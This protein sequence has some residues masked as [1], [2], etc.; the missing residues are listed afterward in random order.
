MGGAMKE[1]KTPSLLPVPPERPAILPAQAAAGEKVAPKKWIKESYALAKQEIG[2]RTT[3]ETQ[4][5][6]DLWGDKKAE[7]EEEGKKVTLEAVGIDITGAQS[8][9]KDAL[10]VMLT[11]RNYK[12]I[13]EVKTVAKYNWTGNLEIEFTIAEYLK[14]YG[15]KKK[16]YLVN[17][18]SGKTI[19][20]HEYARADV[21][22]AITALRELATKDFALYLTQVRYDTEAKALKYE[23]DRYIDKL[24][25]FVEGWKDLSE[26][27][28]E[29]I[30]SGDDTIET[31]SK[32]KPFRI[33]FNPIWGKGITEGE[34]PNFV[35]SEANW[36]QEIGIL[37]DTRP[38]LFDTK[39]GGIGRTKKAKE[40]PILFIKML[41]LQHKDKTAKKRP[42]SETGIRWKTIAEHLR[43]SDTTINRNPAAA[44]KIIQKCLTLAIELGYLKAGEIRGDMIAYT[45]NEDRYYKAASKDTDSLTD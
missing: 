44:K 41:R 24:F 1:N 27:E 3:H 25:R 43:I 31:D 28:R 5:T 39:R 35:L 16:T 22:T 15:L 14:A 18:P 11:E 29:I 33:V 30:K 37:E 34:K 40:K 4:L 2:I 19:K 21:T 6:L 12:G 42:L 8:E 45:M 20:R 38:E 10:A 26:T 32:R 7:L 23:V 17:D 13:G 36:R 9:C